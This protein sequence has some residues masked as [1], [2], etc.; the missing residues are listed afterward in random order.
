MYPSFIFLVT[1]NGTL[2]FESENPAFI[3]LNS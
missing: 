1:V 2:K 3:L